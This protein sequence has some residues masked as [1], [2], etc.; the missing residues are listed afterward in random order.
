MS[1]GTKLVGP[2]A[3]VRET[4]FTRQTF[5]NL[6]KEMVAAGVAAKT[7]RKIDMNCQW[8]VDYISRSK[9]VLIHKSEELASVDEPPVSYR[10]SAE[11]IEMVDLEGLPP[12]NEILHMKEAESLNKLRIDNAVKAKKVVSKRIV[13]AMIEKIDDALNKIIM[14]GEASFVPQL[15]QK[16]RAGDTEEEIKKFW[17]SE[18][19]KII[20][21]VKPFLKRLMNDFLRD[22]E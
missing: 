13:M 15:M 5:Y 21:P 20:S 6:L 7:Q 11:D 3:F 19:G 12:I 1:T 8:M 10:H 4:G 2:S 9:K 17:R 18:I 14:D 16:V 22:K